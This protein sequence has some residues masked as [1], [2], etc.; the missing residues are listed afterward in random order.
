MRLRLN[1]VLCLDLCLNLY[2]NLNPALFRKLF[3]K[4]FRLLFRT[5]FASLFD[6]L[7]EFMFPQLWV[8][9][10]LALYRQTLPPQAVCGPRSGRQ[11]CGMA[12]T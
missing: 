8:I 12:H 3:A 4:S 11:N 9:S 6:S 2:L 7:F 1:P 10:C 5:F